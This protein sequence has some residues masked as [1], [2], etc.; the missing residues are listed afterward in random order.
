MDILI[1]KMFV[2][3]FR[4]HVHIVHRFQAAADIPYDVRSI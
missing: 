3:V 1:F 4:G 2:I